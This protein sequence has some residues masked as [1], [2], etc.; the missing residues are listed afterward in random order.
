MTQDYKKASFWL[1]LLAGIIDL[2]IVVSPVFIVNLVIV[3]LTNFSILIPLLVIVDA[4]YFIYF[5]IHSGSTIGKRLLRLR[6]VNETIE[7]V[8]LKT[9]II[10]EIVGKYLTLLTFGIG[11][12]MILINKDGRGLL[13]IVS[14][15]YV[16]VT[17]SSY[18]PVVTPNQKTSTI[19]KVLFFVL[20]I[21]IFVI[22]MSAALFSF[23]GI[24]IMV[25]G[26]NMNPT[27]KAGQYVFAKQPFLIGRSDV[28]FYYVI[29][30]GRP[31]IMLGRVI[32]LPGEK[33]TLKDNKIIVDSMTLN[34]S[35]V[36]K[37]G[38]ITMGGEYI[39][40]NTPI[41]VPYNNVIIME[42]HRENSIDSRNFG[43]VPRSAI[44][45]LVTF[46]K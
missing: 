10:R 35:R 28:V 12:L 24:P 32:A 21:P 25:F 43:P 20:A 46:P 37:K 16:L 23:V 22:G 29:I 42:D 44:I 36:L 13:D 6:V 27:Y 3:R 15:T 8:N 41:T 39:R 19:N 34:Q 18:N 11:Y 30:E 33:L 26:D 1:R 17:D 7:K 2:I 38:T 5:D 14:K 9:A 45:G 40:E 4:L 31:I